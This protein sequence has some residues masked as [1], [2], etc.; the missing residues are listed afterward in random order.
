MR[1]SEDKQNIT[2]EEGLRVVRLCGQNPSLKEYNTVLAQ[3]NVYDKANL[4]F[5]EM[6]LLAQH[7]FKKENEAAVLEQAFKRLD[8]T[9]KGISIKIPKNLSH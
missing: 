2:K 5:D 7:L 8:K 6:Q 1:F 4:T 3:V 9:G